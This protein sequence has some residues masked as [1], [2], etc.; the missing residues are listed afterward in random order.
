[1]NQLATDHEFCM[2]LFIINLHVHEVSAF[3]IAV[4][5]HEKDGMS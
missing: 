2:S 1:M 3:S 5:V 4:G